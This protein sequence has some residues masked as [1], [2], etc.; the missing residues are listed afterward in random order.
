VF[1]LDNNFNENITKRNGIIFS[2]LEGVLTISKSIWEK[3]NLEM[4][5][6]K[7]EDF[8][9]YKEFMNG[10]INYSEW[11]NKIFLKWKQYSPQKI[12]KLYL[13]KFLKEQLICR[14][15]AKSFIK[16]CKKNFYFI[17]ISGA[18]SIYC[19][20][21]KNELEFDDYYSLSKFIFDELGNL[22]SIHGD[23]FGFNKDKIMEFIIHDYQIEIDKTVAI[24][25]SENDITLLNKAG[26]GILV[27]YDFTFKKYIQKLKPK[28]IKMKKIDFDRI[29]RIIFDYFNINY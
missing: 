25:D 22:K 13:E 10:K 26:L 1:L 16:K 4:G 3:L 8:L 24:G 6:S 18:P 27:N 20:L 19:E 12:N 7:R 9:L 15:D 14:N 5:M 29:L 17:V 2:D 28:V 23:K 11:A 21:A